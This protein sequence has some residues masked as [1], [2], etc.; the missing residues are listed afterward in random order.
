MGVSSSPQK[1]VLEQTR[2]RTPSRLNIPSR[3]FRKPPAR[4]PGIIM[5]F[6]IV[7][8]LQIDAPPE[9]RIQLHLQLRHL[10]PHTTQLLGNRRHLLIDQA[11]RGG[12]HLLDFGQRQRDEGVSDFI[13]VREQREWGQPGTGDMFGGGGRPYGIISSSSASS[14]SFEMS[15][16]SSF[17]F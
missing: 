9:P 14:S 4:N 1:T 17:S 3:E 13:S 16:R 5:Y 11:R 7:L 10:L 12:Q 6:H 8:C 15:S 2:G